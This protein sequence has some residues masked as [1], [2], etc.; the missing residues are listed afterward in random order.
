M[1][2][3]SV[4]PDPYSESTA[5]S[6]SPFVDGH[7]IRSQSAAPRQQQQQQS[8]F[9]PQEQPPLG[10][11]PGLGGSL[12]PSLGSSSILDSTSLDLLRRPASTGVIG[13]QTQSPSPFASPFENPSAAAVRPAPKNVMDLIQEDRHSPLAPQQP[14]QR[15]D[16]YGGY[17]ATGATAGRGDVYGLPRE[18]DRLSSLTH[19][20]ERLQVGP[21]QGYST[22]V[23]LWVIL[24]LVLNPHTRCADNLFHTA[25]R[26]RSSRSAIC[27]FFWASSST[28]P[29]W[30]ATTGGSNAA[31]G[32]AAA[33]PPSCT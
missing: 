22:T 18:T 28:T 29:P 11:P 23:S 13:E 33:S 3:A 14:Y 30:H 12:E 26:N 27:Y 15:A 21:G 9:A 4:G 10:P 17:T 1:R 32:D 20:V 24:L 19:Q 5:T 6:L 8:H 31:A 25:E 16:P 7:L 2:P